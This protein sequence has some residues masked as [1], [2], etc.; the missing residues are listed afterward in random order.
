MLFSH[1]QETAPVVKAGKLIHE[2]KA[3]QRRFGAFAFS[4]VLNLKDEMRGLVIR[5]AHQ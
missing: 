2:G 4:D 5:I 1:G 3:L